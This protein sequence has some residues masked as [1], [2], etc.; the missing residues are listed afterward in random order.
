MKTLSLQPW[1]K[2]FPTAAYSPTAP[3]RTPRHSLLTTHIPLKSVALYLQLV[4]L[5]GVLYADASN[6]SQPVDS[7]QESCSGLI[8]YDPM[9]DLL[10]GGQQHRPGRRGDVNY[11]VAAR[12]CPDI[13]VRFVDTKETSLS[14]WFG[15]AGVD[16]PEATCKLGLLAFRKS[17]T[18][19]VFHLESAQAQRCRPVGGRNRRDRP[20]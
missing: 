10:D 20:R 5:I 16:E 14:Q 6:H 8:I 7:K 12:G 1:S 15:R 9:L 13:V 17:R 19:T 3:M 2:S 4:S 11:L 18:A